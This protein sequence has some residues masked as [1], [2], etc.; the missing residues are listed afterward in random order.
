MTTYNLW[1]RVAT[2]LLIPLFCTTEAWAGDVTA[3]QTRRQ[4]QAFLKSHQP[5]AGGPRRAPGTTPEL[6]LTSR[7][8]GLYYPSGEAATH[9]NACRA[10]FKIGE[11]DAASVRALSSFI[12]NEDDTEATGIIS[13]DGGQTNIDHSADAWYTLSGV[14][15]SGKPTQRGLYIQG[16]KKVLVP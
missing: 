12:F 1:T 14:R 8:S 4:A 13:V 15:L 10:Y 9:I 6:T 3:E 5:A 16:G 11:D 2:M 7:V